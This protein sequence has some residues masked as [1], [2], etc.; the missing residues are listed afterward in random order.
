[1]ANRISLLVIKKLFTIGL[2]EEIFPFH[3]IVSIMSCR[4]SEHFTNVDQ[5]FRPAERSRLV[6]EILLRCPYRSPAP[7]RTGKFTRISSPFAR[8]HFRT[9]TKL[10]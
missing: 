8:T 4:F 5:V 10:F 9:P 7:P 3:T 1:M 2:V 6:Y